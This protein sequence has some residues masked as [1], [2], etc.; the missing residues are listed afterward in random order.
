MMSNHIAYGVPLWFFFI[1]VIS[2][3]VGFRGRFLCK[4]ALNCFYDIL[5]V[6]LSNARYN[7]LPV[8]NFSVEAFRTTVKLLFLLSLVWLTETARTHLSIKKVSVERITSEK[9][10]CI[11]D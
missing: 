7:C 1:V 8:Y 4:L 3:E 6:S 10:S 2:F 11:Y 5:Q 9:R